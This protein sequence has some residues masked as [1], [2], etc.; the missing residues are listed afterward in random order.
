M[1]INPVCTNVFF[2]HLIGHNEPEMVKCTRGQMLEGPRALGRSRIG[3]FPP[4]KL[5]LDLNTCMEN[6]KGN[7]EEN[8]SKSP[9]WGHYLN[10]LG[11]VPL[12]D[13]TYQISRLSEK[14]FMLFYVSLR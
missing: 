8:K 9:W 14:I 3:I 1:I 13:A 2:S 11:Q 7:V 10:K 6:L 4:N 12:G 5:Q